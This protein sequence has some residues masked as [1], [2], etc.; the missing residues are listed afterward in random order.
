MSNFIIV[1]EGADNL[2][3]TTVAKIICEKL[4]YSYLKFPNENHYYGKILREVL[5][6]KR[7]FE[8]VGFQALNIIDRLFTKIEGKI[9]VDRY[10]LSGKIYG[11]SDGIPEEIVEQMNSLLYKPDL[12]FVFTGTPF[13]T[14]NELYDLNN[15]VVQRYSEYIEQNKENERVVEIFANRPLEEVVNEII[16]YIKKFDC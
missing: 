6:G 9:I 13:C 16:S 14:D 2:G 15:T 3:K 5:Q 7:A 8:P 12:T 11:M 4:G 1:F 10:V